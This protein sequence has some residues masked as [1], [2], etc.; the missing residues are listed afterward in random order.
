MNRDE[1]RQLAAAVNSDIVGMT[2]AAQT[3]A[4]VRA[5]LNQRRQT[6]T[7]EQFIDEDAFGAEP[8]APRTIQIAGAKVQVWKTHRAGMDLSDVKGADLYY[9][10]GDRK[11]VLVQYKIPS[12][13][14]RVKL[15]DEQLQDLQ[16][17][18]PVPCLPT[19]RFGCGGWYALRKPGAEA[20]YFP[21]CEARKHFAGHK[22]RKSDLFINGLLQTQFQL[23]FGLCRIGART[24]II[25]LESYRDAAVAEDHVFFQAKNTS[26]GRNA[27]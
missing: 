11:F 8:G 21:A 6:P 26:G 16:D 7:E 25:D 15:D 19:Q 14:G 24:E 9:E 17:A 2:R 1:W 12:V 5:I 3:K 10:L 22:S 4:E 18:C 23:D 13:S 27:I 20:M